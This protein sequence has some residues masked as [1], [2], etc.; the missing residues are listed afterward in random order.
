MKPPRRISAAYLDKVVAHYLN[1]YATT[2]AHLRRLLGQR[3][4]RAA[5]HYDDDVEEGMALV[6]AL[7]AR[8]LRLGILDD[9]EWANARASS[10]HRRGNGT[11]AICAKLGQKGLDSATIDV[12]LEGL[13]ERHGDPDRKAVWRYARKRALGPYRRVVGDQERR[14]KELARLARAGFSY[15]V[16]REVVEASEAPEP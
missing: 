5:A 8:L 13:K 10:L 3:V 11:R 14:R 2:S 1:R 12:A 9:Q 4:R 7:I 15:E 6:D 16:A